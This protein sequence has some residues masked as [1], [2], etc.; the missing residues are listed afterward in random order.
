MLKKGIAVPKAKP[1]SVVNGLLALLPQRE[2]ARLL[3]ACEP[4]ELVFGTVL[5]EAGERYEHAYFPL[6]G[7]ISLV[8]KLAGHRP[9]EMGLIGSEGMLGASLA[10][11]TDQAPMGAVVQGAGSALRLGVVQCQKIVLSSPALQ[12]LMHRYLYVLMKQL[13]Q[14]SACLSF[15]EIEPRLARWLLMTH[16]RAHADCF[17]LT[18]EYLADMLG[19]RRS[20]ITIAAGNLQSRGLIHYRRG[21]IT[22]VD[23]AGLEAASCEC[24]ALL[25][26]DYNASL[27]S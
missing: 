21:E 23:R 6:T 15:H 24:Y 17:H 1:E 3:A 10:Q 22:V 13:S 19:V 20:G 18:H 26:D 27:R 2:R 5:C 7:F 25:I 14:S 4:V 8:T 12:H 16:D 9:L 11:G